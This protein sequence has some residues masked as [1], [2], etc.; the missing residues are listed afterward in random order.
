MTRFVH[1]FWHHDPIE[2]TFPRLEGD[3]NAD[4][5]VVGAG[6]V[7]LSAA[8]HLAS[9]GAKVVLV[10]R[11]V[12]GGQ[13]STRNF[14]QLTAAWD[15]AD[16]RKRD[17]ASLAAYSRSMI[18]SIER[19]VDDE[20]IECE[21]HRSDYW[22][23]AQTKGDLALA[24]KKF[25]SL[26]ADGFDSEW[27]P[28]EKVTITTAPTLGALKTA[29][30]VFDPYR[31]IIGLRDAVVRKGV[32]IFEG[33]NVLTTNSTKHVHIVTER[34]TVVA[35][36]AVIAVN[37]FANSFAGAQGLA[38]PAHIF[39]IGTRRLPADVAKMIGPTIGATATDLGG[40]FSIHPRH[41]QRF[42]KDGR[43][44]FGG[45]GVHVPSSGELFTPELRNEKRQS[46][47]DALF[48]RYPAL[49]RE[50]IEVYWGGTISTTVGERPIIARSP[51]D[52]KIILA[53]ICNGKGM[54][55]GAVS[56]E[57]VSGLISPASALNAEK[58]AFLRY[59]E[60]SAST[61]T[62]IETALFKVMKWPAARSFLNFIMTN[63]KQRS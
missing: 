9:F 60:I 55:L 53:M 2:Q 36:K 51:D 3:L 50:D 29:E 10:E 27:C 54:A 58:E 26:K 59:A 12:V 41:Y 47:A 19:L 1:S 23:F 18:G 14:G 13:S 40:R 35:E 38:M 5:V 15:Y 46:L 62:K 63:R 34:G 4:V 25:A 16:A 42:L 44:L 56:G 45:G 20:G 57:L 49:K 32:Q 48:A 24:K 39:A 8:Y 6:V 37:S 17:R 31:F 22:Q 43:L 7:G 33:T 30:A 21:L 28:A 52:E 11:T 61:K